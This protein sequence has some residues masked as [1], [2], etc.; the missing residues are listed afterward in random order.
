MIIRKTMDGFRVSV[1]DG[2]LCHQGGTFTRHAPLTRRE[3]VLTLAEAISLFDHAEMPSLAAAAAKLAR[4]GPLDLWPLVE[5]AA[6]LSH[7]AGTRPADMPRPQRAVHVVV[8]TPDELRI[9]ANG[10]IVAPR[11]TRLIMVDE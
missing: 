2:C 11:H 10:L 7:R 5:E 6:R 9:A 1:E 3:D 8:W 4:R